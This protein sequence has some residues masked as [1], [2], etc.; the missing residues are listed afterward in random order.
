[1]KPFEKSE[2]HEMNDFI[3]NLVFFENNSYKML[4]NLFLISKRK[5]F[6]SVPLSKMGHHDGKGSNHLNFTVRP[7]NFSL[8]APSLF[9]RIY[10]LYYR[11]KNFGIIKLS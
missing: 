3:R 11:N 8:P 4:C 10:Y 7:D 6:F 2:L 5:F 9:S 1:M